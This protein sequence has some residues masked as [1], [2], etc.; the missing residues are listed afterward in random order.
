MRWS[1]LVFHALLIQLAAVQ[2]VD[3]T[4]VSNEPA[5][6][7]P[8]PLLQNTEKATVPLSAK[9]ADS[10]AVVSG[11]VSPEKLDSRDVMWSFFSMIQARESSRPG[12]GRR[13]LVELV[14]LDDDAAQKML[15]YIESTFLQY[16]QYSARALHGYCGSL[17]PGETLQSIATKLSA[18]E[19]SAYEW[20]NARLAMLATEL[21]SAN[22]SKVDQW[23]A[24][25]IASST[26]VYRINYM[27]LLTQPDFN[28]DLLLQR[29]ST[30]CGTS[31]G[32][33]P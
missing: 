6:G 26:A 3:A 27:K 10:V 22:L 14:K 13:V 20:R 19:T 28:K 11:A 12:T 1:N 31:G 33:S 30:L 8:L 16:K 5:A 9:F 2:I 15:T 17:S 24:A 23:V 32:V 4:G 21:G 29:S 25:N 7:A 18:G